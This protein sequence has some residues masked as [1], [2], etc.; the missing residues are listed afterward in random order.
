MTAPD[1]SSRVIIIH[2]ADAAVA[3]FTRSATELDG[4]RLSLLQPL[5]QRRNGLKGWCPRSTH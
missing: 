4:R 2:R 1:H 5:P 3:L